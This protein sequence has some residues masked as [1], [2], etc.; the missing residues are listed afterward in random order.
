MEGKGGRGGVGGGGR[1]AKALPLFR[2]LSSWTLL[3]SGC[4]R[5]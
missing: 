4:A 5:A 3:A 1:E 2:I